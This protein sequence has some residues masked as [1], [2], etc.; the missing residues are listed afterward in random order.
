V[1]EEPDL[2]EAAAYIQGERPKL[3]E[4]HVWSVLMELGDP[5]GAEAER[6]ALDLL[7]STHPEISTKD[8]KLILREW[9]AYVDL[10]GQ[11]DW[12]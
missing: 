11:E 3:D 4:G 12:E 7:G 9:R 10:A 5:P 1:G 8:V 6:L 2:A